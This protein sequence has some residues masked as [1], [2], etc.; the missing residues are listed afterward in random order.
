VLFTRTSDF[1][2]RLQVARRELALESA[3]A[4]L[5]TYHLL[6][7]DDIA[8][9]SEDQAET[10][11]LFELIGSRYERRSMLITANQPFGAWRRKPSTPRYAR[12]QTWARTAA[13]TR[14]NQ[15]VPLH[16]RTVCQIRCRDGAGSAPVTGAIA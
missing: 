9:V 14:N 8:Y 4:V 12:P 13:D 15:I 1:V 3:L 6:I 2:Q 16:P 7:L 5:G 11:M 10:S